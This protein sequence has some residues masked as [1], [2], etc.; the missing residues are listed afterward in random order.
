LFARNG[1]RAVR[2]Q[3]TSHCLHLSPVCPLSLLFLLANIAQQ[4]PGAAASAAARPASAA[5]RWRQRRKLIPWRWHRN[6]RLAALASHGGSTIENDC[7]LQLSPV[8]C[9]VPA[10]GQRQARR[11]MAYVAT[12][13][14]LAGD[15]TK[16][17]NVYRWRRWRK[18][19]ARYLTGGGVLCGGRRQAASV[20]ARRTA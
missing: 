13:R 9:G 18:G 20:P 1:K 11:H 3:A 8:S 5:A 19:M 10:S 4:Q 16:A 2:R 12:R 14:V 17:N 7:R 6:V 15:G